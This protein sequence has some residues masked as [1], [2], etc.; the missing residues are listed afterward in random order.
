MTFAEFKAWLDGFSEGVVRAPSEQQWKRILAKLE[1]VEDRP[2][3]F[4]HD[5]I[6]K[7]IYTSDYIGDHFT[8]TCNEDD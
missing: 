6:P 7:K 5:P 3:P 8:V 1:E 2:A 4:I